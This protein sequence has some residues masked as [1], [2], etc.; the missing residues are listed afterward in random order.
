MDFCINIKKI[1]AIEAVN[2]VINLDGHQERSFSKAELPKLAD[3][4][5]MQRRRLS[6][7]AKLAMYCALEVTKHENQPLVSV[8]S[9][10]HGD[11]HKT[12]TMLHDLAL[13]EDIS[14]TAF[15]LSVHNAVSG[16][17]TIFTQNTQASTTVS[18]GKDTFFM[19]LVEAYIRLKTGKH[20][21][22]LLVHSDQVL[23]SPYS[24]YADELQVDHA[25]ALIL[26]KDNFVGQ[27]LS[28][29]KYNNISVTSD[30]SLTELPQAVSFYRWLSD[31]TK[32]QELDMVANQWK[33]N[34]LNN[35]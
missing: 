18:A 30:D 33:I 8:F 17:F 3:L 9:S 26:T 16:L 5:P 2:P 7:F 13:E 20:E 35:E 24:Q 28:I 19:A 29:K 23:P 31:M 6:P 25:V 32:P 15:S 1:V 4:K 27:R 14:P 21:Q 34:R 11:L 22:V 12:S 10:R